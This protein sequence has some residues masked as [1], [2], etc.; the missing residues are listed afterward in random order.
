[1]RSFAAKHGLK[2]VL[3]TTRDVGSTGLNY[4]GWLLAVRNA[5]G[6]RQT[7]RLTERIAGRITAAIRRREEEEGAGCS[8]TIALRKE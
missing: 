7:S 2:V 5:F 1:M 8:Y 6:Q 3:A 4:Y